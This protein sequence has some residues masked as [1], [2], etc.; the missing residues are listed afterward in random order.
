MST[1]R[2]LLTLVLLC[3]ACTLKWDGN[4]PAV[5][6]T[7]TPPTFASLR[8]LNTSTS[9][10]AS[11]MTGPDGAPWAAFC[12]FW[13]RGSG[14]NARNCKRM[15]LVR[16]DGLPGDE[17]ISADSFQLRPTALF[18]LRDDPETQRRSFTMHF[19]GDPET[20][21]VTFDV[22]AGRASYGANPTSDVLFYWAQETA[23]P[24]WTVY[25]RDRRHERAIPIPSSVDGTGQASG[26][27]AIA[28][29]RK[30]SV[31]V[32]RAPDGET[33]VHSTTDVASVG[34]GIRPADYF[35]DEPHGALVT[36]GAD[37]VR[38]VPLQ[39]GPELPLSFSP[40]DRNTVAV[41]NDTFYFGDARGLWS[42]PLDGASAATLIQPGAV[43]PRAINARGTVVY[44]TEASTTYTG[45]AGDGWIGDWRFMERGRLLRFSADGARLHFLE[46]AATVDVTGDLT[47]ATSPGVPNRLLAINV[48]AYD[49][50]PDGRIVAVEN[51]IQEGT[52]NRLVV[53]DERSGEKRWVVPSTFDFFEVPGGEAVVADVVTGQDGYDIYLAPIPR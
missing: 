41:A 34:L 27:L 36:Y 33:N 32:V 30:G 24:T 9:S 38:S 16:I 47:S 43:R 52:W 21:D 40:I 13:S 37:G 50:L 12:E 45:A 5:E 25:R 46:H 2:G 20:S 15:H 7:G 49:E 48:H 22:P 28:F 4:A 35:F 29:D 18:V 17:M 10:R 31:L 23:P 39:G 14:N 6:L 51:A 42:V 19:P 1:T 3:S 11:L 53:I 44:G 26:A 8:K